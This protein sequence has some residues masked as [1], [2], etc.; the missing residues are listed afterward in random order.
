M[1]KSHRDKVDST[2]DTQV[3]ASIVRWG[4]GGPDLL[5]MYR[6]NSD[7]LDKHLRAQ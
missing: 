1:G 7:M 2:I 4:D 6:L 3:D 5:D